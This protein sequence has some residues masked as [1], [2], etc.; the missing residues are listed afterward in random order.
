AAAGTNARARRPV[1]PPG[2][3]SR[4]PAA[5]RAE[6]ATSHDRAERKICDLLTTW[7]LPAVAASKR[8]CGLLRKLPGGI[9]QWTII[10]ENVDNYFISAPTSSRYGAAGGV[11]H[12]PPRFGAPRQRPA[13]IVS[14]R[15]A[16]LPGA[17]G[18]LWCALADARFGDAQDL[19]DLGQGEALVVVEGDHDLLPLTEPVDRVGQDPL[20]LLGLEDSHR[21]L[22][23]LVLQGVDQAEP[24]T[25]LGADREQLVQ[26]DHRHERDLVEDLVQLVGGDAQLLSHLGVAGAAMQP[27]LEGDVR[28]LDLAGFEPD[29]PGDPVDGPQ[30]VDD[31]AL[32]P[33]DRVGLE[34]DAPFKIVFLDRVDEAEDAV[35]HQIGL[36]DVWWQADLD[37]PTHAL[38]QAR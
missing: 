8:R 2:R 37:P 22:G 24:V 14:V 32:D 30:L 21:V 20:H 27:V 9:S 3:R 23:A 25:T 13:G 5:S 34:L 12:P 29:R 35:R 10:R 15:P 16:S 28:L 7:E 6:T 31:R 4:S 36:L 38:N 11:A 18:R 1:P 33:R 19:P 26:G 17:G